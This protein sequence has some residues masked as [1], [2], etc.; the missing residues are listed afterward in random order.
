[1][2]VLSAEPGP[3]ALTVSDTRF[4]NRASDFNG[5][6]FCS[7]SLTVQISNSSTYIQQGL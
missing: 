6:S 7:H 4:H 1:M 2:V 5:S 3:A